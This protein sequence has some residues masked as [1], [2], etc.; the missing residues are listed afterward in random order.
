MK[1][2][3][4]F[5]LL[6]I[7]LSVMLVLLAIASLQW[8]MAHDAPTEIYV[9][10]LMD[11]FGRIPY[12]D[13]WE[14]NLPGSFFAYM[15]IGKLIGYTNDFKF[16]LF[17]LAY[18]IALCGL[19]ARWLRQLGWKIA[20]AAPVLFG[21]VYLHVGA[22]QSLQREYLM[23]LPAMLSL[24]LATE[25][26]RLND[27]IRA[28]LVGLLFGLAATIK[29]H[30]AIGFPVALLGGYQTI[31]ARN[32][33]IPLSFRRWVALSLLAGIGFAAP[34]IAIAAYMIT[35]GGLPYYLDIFRNYYPLY[36]NVTR[37]LQIVKGYEHTIYLIR[38]FLSFGGFALWFIPAVIGAFVALSSD[39]LTA[40]S[41]R[42]IMIIGLLV[43][44]YSIY[45]IFSGQFFGYHLLPFLYFLFMLTPLCFLVNPKP[46]KTVWNWLPQ[47]AF[48]LV[49]LVNVDFVPDTVSWA[50]T[51]YAP[52]QPAASPADGR[53]DEIATFLKNNLRPGDTVQPLDWVAGG[54]MQGMLEAQAE[55]ATPYLTDMQF[56]HDVSKP[57]IQELRE[58]FLRHLE[59][60]PPRFIVEYKQYPWIG[61]PDTS[62]EFLELWLWI[63]VNY[64]SVYLD[65]NLEIY[66]RVESQG[67]LPTKR[68]LLVYPPPSNIAEW[69]S[70]VTDIT[71]MPVGE[72][73]IANT[74]TLSAMTA[75]YLYVTLA[76]AN[77]QKSDPQKELETWASQSLFRIGEH[78]GY[79]MRMVDYVAGVHPCRIT[80]PQDVEFGDAIV[81]EAASST[82]V[83][84][85][86]DQL[87]CVQLHW[88]TKY[89]IAESYKIAAHVIDASG[90]LVAQYDSRPVGYLAP[91]PTWTPGKV[92]TD[93]FA[94]LLPK[95]LS[96]GE[97]QVQIILYNET[98]QER[99]NIV[100][101]AASADYKVIGTFRI[102]Q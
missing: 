90:R 87:V 92:V 1:R 38:T 28:T 53:V 72:A 55:I 15:A 24:F 4:L 97:Y 62:S 58:D 42:R 79:N 94:I 33:P 43:L 13:L 26:P 56:F 20:W 12:R 19:S 64:R 84:V 25:A 71:V 85:G 5:L 32:K 49:L 63:D 17:D 59:Q 80:T 81:L 86:S 48:V 27:C 96:P 14:I 16:R 68:A 34:L 76:F 31:M 29:P 40:E 88:R 18:L 7:P 91:T 83:N 30:F 52:P 45:P 93:R 35:S 61:G 60:A 102:E 2:H 82:L 36:A 70:D 9:A 98:T 6:F 11:R 39:T 22:A 37:D 101:M 21:L 74:A 73:Q 66:E 46:S 10:F 51:H 99:L 44:A 95:S 77:E 23:L 100:G 65:K 75:D 69:Y 50:V 8:R 57:Y 41:R 47:I 3:L 54:V 89:P 78:W 67:I